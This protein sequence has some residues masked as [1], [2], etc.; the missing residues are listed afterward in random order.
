MS[1]RVGRL[2]EAPSGRPADLPAARRFPFASRPREPAFEHRPGQRRV[3]DAA[4]RRERA[5]ELEV[6]LVE[7]EGDLFRAR[8]SNLDL[9]IRETLD[10]LLNAVARPEVTLFS[11]TG[12]WRDPGLL[13]AARHSPSDSSP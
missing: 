12:E 13:P 5:E 10:K 11:I 2:L 1:K 3:S 4:R 8:G 9:E 7:T 6:V